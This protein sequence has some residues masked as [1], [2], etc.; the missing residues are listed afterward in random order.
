MNQPTLFFRIGLAVVTMTTGVSAVPAA[1]PCTPAAIV[2]GPM[3]DISLQVSAALQRSGVSSGRPATG[4]ATC[5]VVRATVRRA[6]EGVLVSIQDQYGRRSHRAVS[7]PAAAATLIES[8]ARTDVPADVLLPHAHAGEASLQDSAGLA[9]ATVAA[10]P[11]LARWGAG[12]AAES[13]MAVD[14]STWW[15][16]R[17]AGC[18]RIGRVCLETAGRLASDAG[19]TGGS[20]AVPTDRLAV[21]GLLGARMPF[22][23]G[24]LT[25]APGLSAG[26]GWMRSQSLGGAG[27]HEEEEGDDNTDAGLVANTV[28]MRAEASV[29]LSWPVYRGFLLDL[30][31]ASTLAP[32]ARTNGFARDGSRAAAEPQW[33]FHAALGARWGAP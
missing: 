31:L 28:G 21:E 6:Q 7:S 14:A 22:A 16:A 3:P 19:S 1:T 5:G 33:L 30:N 12:L 26:V 29:G 13:S 24:R 11:A 32:M 8:W 18:V 17:L 25:V 10:S 15:G 4:A 2:E 27:D 20:H 9:A 23:I